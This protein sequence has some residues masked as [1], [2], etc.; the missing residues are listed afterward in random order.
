MSDRSARVTL[1]RDHFPGDHHYLAVRIV[2]LERALGE[3]PRHPDQLGP[4]ADHDAERCYLVLGG[5]AHQ[6]FGELDSPQATGGPSI[7][8]Y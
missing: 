1:L 8:P 5:Q 7:W 3:P 2:G 4:Q 6:L